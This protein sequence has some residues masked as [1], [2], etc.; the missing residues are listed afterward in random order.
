M[1]S[2]TVCLLNFTFH[3]L[4]YAQH[5]QFL[6]RLTYPNN[7]HNSYYHPRPTL[8]IHILPYESPPSPR[9]KKSFLPP[10]HQTHPLFKLPFHSLWQISQSIIVAALEFCKHGYKKKILKLSIDQWRNTKSYLAQWKRAGLI[11]RRTSDRN[12]E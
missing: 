6:F 5:S 7:P 10:P 11:T 9:P 2:R 1:G 3:I 12:R 4:D 8:H